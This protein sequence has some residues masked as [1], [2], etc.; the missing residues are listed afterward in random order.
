MASIYIVKPLSSVQSN[1]VIKSQ[2]HQQKNSW[3]RRELNPRLLGEKQLCDLC[4]MPLPVQQPIR[5]CSGRHSCN[6]SLMY[7]LTSDLIQLWSDFQPA[8]LRRH[9]NHW[10][11]RIMTTTELIRAWSGRCSCRWWPSSRPSSETSSPSRSSSMR[12]RLGQFLL[13]PNVPWLYCITGSP[14]AST[15]WVQLTFSSLCSLYSKEY[16]Q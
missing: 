8:S 16:R 11:R 9:R 4:A 13:P 6:Q 5:T 10:I 7:N 3:E 15:R 14:L 1:V 12:T 2:Q